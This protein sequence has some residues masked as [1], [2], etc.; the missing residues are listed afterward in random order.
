MGC[1]KIL[2]LKNKNWRD[3]EEKV[4]TQRG[5]RYLNWL[6]IVETLMSD[7]EEDL[8]YVQY[9]KSHLYKIGLY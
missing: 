6:N 5:T 8:M 2:N 9:R 7:E 4:E 3:D 1:E